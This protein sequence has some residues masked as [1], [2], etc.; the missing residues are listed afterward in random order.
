MRTIVQTPEF[1][2][3]LIILSLVCATTCNL[4]A[5]EGVKVVSYYG[6]E[7]CIELRNVQTRVVLCPAAGGRVLEYSLNGVNAIYNPPGEEGWIWKQGG[8]SGTMNAGRFD[9]GPEQI[10]PKR[11]LLW[12]GRWKGEITG[13]YSARMISPEDPSTGVRLTREFKLDERTSRLDCTQI[14]KNISSS[15]KDYCHWSRTFA[16]GGG[17]CVVPISS[18]SRFPNGYVMYEAGSLMNFRPVD[19]AVVAEEGFLKIGPTPKNPKLG[20]D[21]MTG[22]FAYLAPNNLLFVKSYQTYPNR[23]Y[24]EVAGLTISIWF[25]DGPMVELEPI[26]PRERLEPGEQGAFTE[27]WRLSD[28]PSPKSMSEVRPKVVAKRVEELTR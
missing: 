24:N 3:A 16:V 7:D 26:G 18:P 25:P 4:A 13:R 15:S 23:V 17:Y 21:S 5:Q 8:K 19:P 2:A 1:S 22:W 9:I 12:Q 10:V 27:T 6:Y 11:D 14:I 28:Y 20:M